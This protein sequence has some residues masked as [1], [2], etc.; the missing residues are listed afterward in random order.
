MCVIY[1]GGDPCGSSYVAET[2]SYAEVRWNKHNSTTKSLERSK[3]L[4]DNIYDCFT[5]TIVSN[6]PKNAMARKNLDASCNDLLKPDF[7]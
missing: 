7:N 5:W 1:R 2:K 3:Q 6:T 4:Q